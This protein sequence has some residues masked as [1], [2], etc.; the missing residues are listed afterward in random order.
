MLD[1]NEKI[2]SI[3]DM[4]NERKRFAH[5]FIWDMMFRRRLAQLE[6]DNGEFDKMDPMEV[7]E[8]VMRDLYNQNLHKFTLHNRSFD[9][10]LERADEQLNDKDRET[11]ET[12]FFSRR[13][14]EYYDD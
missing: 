10:L 4:H 8:S 7:I 9:K 12:I 14:P 5:E 3:T 2:Y 11:L 6:N 13:N 1:V